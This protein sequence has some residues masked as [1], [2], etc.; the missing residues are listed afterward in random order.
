LVRLRGRAAQSP[1]GPASQQRWRPSQ[2]ADFPGALKLL[3]V[4]GGSDNWGRDKGDN[5][6][7]LLDVV[8]LAANAAHQK[9]NLVPFVNFINLLQDLIDWDSFLQ[10]KD[11]GPNSYTIGSFNIPAS[12]VP[13]LIAGTQQDLN[14]FLAGLPGGGATSDGQ[15]AAQVLQGMFHNTDFSFPI[16]TNPLSAIGM[17]LGQTTDLFQLNLRPS[18]NF[19]PGFNPDGSPAG[20][21]VTIAQIPLFGIPFLNALAQG[22]FSASLNIGFGYDTRGL[23]QYEQ[24]VQS[25]SPDPADLLNGLFITDDING[26]ILPVVSVTGLGQIALDVGFPGFLDGNIGGYL[27]GTLGLDLNAALGTDHSRC[28]RHSAS[29]APDSMP[30]RPCHCGEHTLGTRRRRC[31]SICRRGKSAR[32]RRL[33]GPVRAAAAA[34]IRRRSRSATSPSPAAPTSATRSPLREERRTIT[35]PPSPTSGSVPSTASSR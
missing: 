11:F 14:A 15:T 34:A 3:D 23:Q 35:P 1:A 8:K 16:I 25:G 26:S 6:F 31:C 32:R 30:L 19:G 2:C 18:L 27:E 5:K 7:T 13:T 24:S 29:S 17:L 28:S 9:V 4:A 22:D 10:G 12:G 33:P 21:L 20:D